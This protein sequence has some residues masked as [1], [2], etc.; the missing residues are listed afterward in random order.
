MRAQP[1]PAP[2]QM[3]R[4]WQKKTNCCLN[5]VNISDICSLELIGVFSVETEVAQVSGD[6]QQDQA[7]EQLDSGNQ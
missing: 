3:K 4:S 7:V 1:L 2:Q 6:V 5:Q